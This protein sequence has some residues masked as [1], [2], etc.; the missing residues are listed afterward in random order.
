M[1]HSITKFNN[2]LCHEY[3]IHPSES[4]HFYK[5]HNSIWEMGKSSKL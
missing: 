2:H 3:M 5:V 1:L 4:A